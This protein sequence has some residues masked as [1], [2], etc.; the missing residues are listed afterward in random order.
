M[1]V[2]QTSI[3]DRPPVPLTVGQLTLPLH[4]PL[5]A[6]VEVFYPMTVNCGACGGASGQA[7]WSATDPDAFAECGTCERFVPCSLCG[8]PIDCKD[9]EP[10]RLVV[11]G[12]LEP[13]CVDCWKLEPDADSYDTWTND[14]C[15][16]SR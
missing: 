2:T 14:D 4:L 6:A 9:T 8:D 11:D 15:E 1:P 13:V 7:V 3:F 12:R 10:D 5:S 16:G